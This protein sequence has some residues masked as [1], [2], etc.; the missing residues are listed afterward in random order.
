MSARSHA[1]RAASRNAK[2][3][4][5]A[6]RS[7]L[8][9]LRWALLLLL[10]V[11]LCS[12][13]SAVGPHETAL[14][15]RFGKLEPALRHSGLVIAL[16][17]PFEEVVKVPIASVQ[18]MSLEAWAAPSGAPPVHT[19]TFAASQRTDGDQ[20]VNTPYLHPVKHGYTLTGDA[21]IVQ[22][23]FALRYRIADAVS[24]FRLG[25]Q[26]EL[27]IESLLYGALTVTLAER[28][29]DHVLT[30]GLEET[31]A[32]VLARAQVEADRLGLGVHFTAF[33]VR[34][35]SPARHVLPAFEEV[36]NAQMEAR[37]AL[38]SARSYQV[39]QLP[40]AEAEAYRIRQIAQ[41]DAQSIISSARGETSAFLS[42][43][44]EYQRNPELVRTRLRAETLQ[45]VMPNIVSKS[46]LPASQSGARILLQPRTTP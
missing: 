19:N 6:L 31:R 24:W 8:S 1:R 30:S 35:L 42:L 37:T 15:L 45:E 33:E 11:Y 36:V 34:E 9:L 26:R 27:L 2:A 44:G 39:S 46:F 22:G 5:D 12:G 18:E 25:E 43:F 32:A 16:P 28:S 41:A 21:N 14:V 40:Q 7:S 29:V 4:L 38:E 20:V 10:L 13:I 17:P 3:I 23:R